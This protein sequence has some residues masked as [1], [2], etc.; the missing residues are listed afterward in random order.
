MFASPKEIKLEVHLPGHHMTQ[1]EYV[2][3]STQEFK[4]FQE[5]QNSSEDF[6]LSK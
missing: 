4:F 3:T 6:S 5:S 2:Q 1:Q